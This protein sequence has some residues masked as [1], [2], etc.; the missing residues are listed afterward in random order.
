MQAKREESWSGLPQ[1]AFALGRVQASPVEVVCAGRVSL[2]GV[3]AEI[4]FF[5][6]SFFF[7]LPWRLTPGRARLMISPEELARHASRADLWLAV[8]GRVYDV[9]AFEHPGGEEA[10]L[11]YAGRDASQGFLRVVDH[12]DNAN[13]TQAMATCFRGKLAPADPKPRP[14]PAVIEKTVR[15]QKIAKKDASFFLGFGLVMLLMLIMFV[16]YR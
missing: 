16:Y 3:P 15:A 8:N 7:F 14:R 12:E 1:P 6:S 13:V 10:L 5:F 9:S 2:P 4:S 11:R